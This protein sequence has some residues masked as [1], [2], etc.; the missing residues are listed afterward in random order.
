MLDK[1]G[2]K[3]KNYYEL[4]SDMEER[5]K[6]LFGEDTNLS[7]N[8]PIGVFIRLFS[9]FLS[10]T[11]ELAEKVY[12]SAYITR[13]EGVQLDRLTAFFNTSRN[14]EQ[15]ATA[16]LSITGTPNVT[17]LEGTRFETESGIDFALT[18]NVTLDG[19]GLGSGKVVSLTPGIN[20]NVSAGA[21]TI[22]SEPSADIL[23][24]TNIEDAE[25]GRD[26]ETDPELLARM[27]ASGASTGSGTPDAIVSEVLGV[28][29]VRAANI[30]VNNESTTVNGLPP[31][32]N[33]VYVLGGD[34][35]TIANA[36]YKHYVGLQFFGSQS[37]TVK[38]ISG[39]SH[40]ISFT[41]AT[42]VNIFSNVTLTTNNTFTTTGVN[43]VKDAIV[44]IIGGTTNDGTLY[45]GLNMG[46][47]V[48]Y[49]KIIAAVMGT[50]GVVDASI[51]IGKTVESQ[52]T[53]NIQIETNEVAQINVS[54]I[55]VTE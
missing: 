18:E 22:Q 26:V 23:E 3:R 6:S 4:Q 21:I 32:S 50:Q 9:W 27:K 36:L 15:Y 10:K 41:P 24:V 54:D 42:Q 55:T 46:E 39:N 14:P 12:N 33:A 28:P 11:W 34:G 20:G 31:H 40:T 2:F 35:Q 5:A 37:Y 47:D 52:T 53:S 16:E 48:I 13:A 43:D 29:G 30:S 51:T 49:S 25:G 38:D 8:S 44:K 7:E 19:N 45:V 17:I 1:Y